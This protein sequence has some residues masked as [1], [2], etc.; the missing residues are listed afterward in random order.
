MGMDYSIYADKET[1][2]QSEFPEELSFFFEQ[3]R[4]Y[5]EHS[6]VGQVSTLLDIDLSCFQHYDWGTNDEQEEQQFWQDIDRFS[7][8]VLELTTKIEQKPDYFE[9]VKHGQNRNQ[10]FTQILE[11]FQRG[12]EAKAEELFYTDANLYP[13]DDGYLSSGRIIEDLQK[14]QATLECY[15]KNGVK[16]IKLM[17]L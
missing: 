8:K 12:D 4:G 13:P 2:C 6:E 11:A 16:K 7:G 1:H 17:Y 5:D 14:L 3:Y 9:A 15:R 10:S